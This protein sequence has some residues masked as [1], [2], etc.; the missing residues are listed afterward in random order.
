M[1]TQTVIDA[2]L[3]QASTQSGKPSNP[4]VTADT[5]T[6]IYT[7]ME[8][9]LGDVLLTGDGSCLTGIY[10]DDFD[11]T[12][13]KLQVKSGN[14]ALS[15]DNDP[16]LNTVR[17]QLGE[18]FAGERRE[19][20]VPLGPLGTDF[21]KDVWAALTTIPF[22]R[23]AGYGELAEWLGRP[24]AARAVGAANGKNPI[25]IIVP[26]HRVIGANGSLTGYAWGEERK[27]ALLDLEAGRSLGE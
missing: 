16:V 21:Q 15:V 25:S 26:C 4:F 17:T 1:K 12:L 20:D 22:G 24:K 9:V 19:F 23:T 11:S 5:G 18:Y 8:S 7:V 10:L 13:E 6:L 2:N 27:Q 3:P 14:T